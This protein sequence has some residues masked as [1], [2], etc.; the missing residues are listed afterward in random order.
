MSN[1]ILFVD[2]EPNVLDGFQRQLRKKYEIDTALGAR[3]GLEM[4]RKKGPYAAVV[5]D[6]RMPV[7]DGIT[8]L[9]EVKRHSPH[10]VRLM[11][12]GN[13]DQ[14]TAINAVNEG[15]VFRF[16]TKPCPPLVLTNCLD[17][18]LEQYRL[19]KA[20]QELLN[21]TLNGAIKLLTDILSMA[22][23]EAYGQAIAVRERVKKVALHMEMS[24]AWQVE[25]AAML[26]PIA[27]IT[28][29]LPLLS[30]IREREPLTESEQSVVR[31]LPEINRRLIENIPRLDKVAQVL[32]YQ[33]KCF[34]GS[35]FPEDT[36]AGSDIPL[37]SRI[38]K[39][40]LD[41]RDWE[42]K[43]TSA[44]TA[45]EQMAKQTDWYDHRVLQV[46]SHVVLEDAGKVPNMV[47]IELPISGL[48]AGQLLASN[49]E[50]EDGNVLLKAGH[51]LTE[52]VLAK[53]F[54]FSQI[55]NIRQPIRV[56]AISSISDE[57][58]S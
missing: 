27:L 30:K 24:D 38:L 29:P 6:M 39:V 18:A 48:R 51:R 46:M 47:V 31:Q 49:I 11:L 54:N 45:L 40:A 22:A 17:A 36:V 7:M 8:F 33:N 26:A 4:I 37:G 58:H 14:Q 56:E 55:S 50:T 23:P 1:K 53:I 16:M 28:V 21:G 5:A 2:D 3:L 41:L 13:A 19:V 44:Q 12:T 32:Y 57:N 10:T 9:K 43:G 52:T 34:D 15:N 35:G 20:E 42:I 25:L